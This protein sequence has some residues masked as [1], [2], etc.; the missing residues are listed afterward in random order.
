MKR[1][2][3]ML[4][5]ALALT[6]CSAWGG[7]ENASPSSLVD[8][9]VTVVEGNAS[10]S[11]LEVPEEPQSQEEHELWGVTLTAKNV[12]PTG[13]TIIC[14]QSGGEDVAQLHS[15]NYYRLEQLNGEHWD[16][17]EI[18][19]VG[20]YAFT[21]EAWIIP[22]EDSVEWHTGWEWLYGELAPG[23]YRIVKEIENFRGT[24]DYDEAEYY[25]EFTIE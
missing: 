23:T 4:C 10:P 21:A 25:A 6:G 13:L 5:A 3:I 18:V 24:G 7:E 9:P 17:C 12:T 20:E 11:D 2:L 19:F 16:E 8:R 14:T 1:L 22:L 15:G